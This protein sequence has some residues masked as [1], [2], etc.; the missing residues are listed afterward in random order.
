MSDPRND[1]SQDPLAT[2]LAGNPEA[3]AFPPG[4]R[5]HGVS[6]ATLA[7]DDGEVI[8]YLRRRFVPQPES[9]AALGVHTVV[10]GERQDQVA[11]RRLGDPEAFWR[12]ADANRVLDPHELVGEVGRRLIVPLPEGV[13]GLPEEGEDG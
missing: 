11:A 9:F 10:Q 13:P 8:A 7:D 4:S 6:I 12:L 1:P 5:Y 2:L 3:R